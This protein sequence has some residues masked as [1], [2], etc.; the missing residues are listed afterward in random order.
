MPEAFSLPIAVLKSVRAKRRGDT[1]MAPSKLKLPT[2]DD[3]NLGMPP[4]VAATRA[5]MKSVNRPV[6]TESWPITLPSGAIRPSQP[7][8]KSL[9]LATSSVS[10]V[11]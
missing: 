3:A 10:N 9:P 8:K 1:S 11:R 4:P 2:T 5:P 6:A 7:S